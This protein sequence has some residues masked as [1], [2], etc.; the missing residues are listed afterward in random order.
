MDNTLKGLCDILDEEADR[1]F[2]A[3]QARETVGGNRLGEGVHGRTE[4]KDKKQ[5]RPQVV[6]TLFGIR[7]C[8]LF[9]CCPSL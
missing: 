2:R 6:G 1:A 7:Y 5:Y 8:G 4:G 9:F 3:V